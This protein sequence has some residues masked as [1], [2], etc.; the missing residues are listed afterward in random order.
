MAVKA[1]HDDMRQATRLCD[2]SPALGIA[3]Y[4][5]RYNPD[6]SS[7]DGNHV[8][9]TNSP[10]VAERWLAG[11]NVKLFRVHPIPH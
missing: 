3:C 5:G 4:E 2:D 11:E 1:N 7:W 9:A 10:E 6:T 8:G